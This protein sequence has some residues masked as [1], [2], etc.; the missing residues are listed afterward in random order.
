MSVDDSPVKTLI[1]G[2]IQICCNCN[3]HCP[4]AIYL[5]ALDS[6]KSSVLSCNTQI[7]R[8]GEGVKSTASRMIN[9]Q[10]KIGGAGSGSESSPQVDKL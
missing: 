5:L 4:L 8:A 3:E 7:A 10:H 2:D 1:R 9:L 6:S